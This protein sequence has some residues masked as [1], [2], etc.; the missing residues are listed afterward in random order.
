MSTLTILFIVIFCPIS[1]DAGTRRLGIGHAI[2]DGA[3]HSAGRRVRGVGA[4][5]S[6]SMK[7]VGMQKCHDGSS[8]AIPE[9]GSPS[10]DWTR[11]SSSRTLGRSHSG[12]FWRSRRTWQ[13]R[14]CPS[15]GRLSRNLSSSSFIR[16]GAC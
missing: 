14:S 6:E 3:L 7:H 9:A 13:E 1:I 8:S 15:G 10:G 5:S 16:L 4:M 11:R 12:F 2:A